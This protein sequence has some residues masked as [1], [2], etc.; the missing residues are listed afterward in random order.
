MIHGQAFFRTRQSPL[1]RILCWGIVFFVA[2]IIRLD[3]YATEP[4]KARKRWAIIPVD[5]SAAALADLLTA[6]LS[7]WDQIDLVERTEI[8]LLLD[9]L[10]LNSAGLVESEH[11]LTLGRLHHADALL[12]IDV[13]KDDQQQP[14][15][16]NQP[17]PHTVSLRLRLVETRTSIRYLDIL[18]PVEKL[19]QEVQAAVEVL[20]N[21]AEKLAFADKDLQYVGVMPINSGEPGEMLKPFCDSLTML[22]ESHLHHVPSI[23]VLERSDLNR[24]RSESRLSG[25]ELDLQVSARLLEIAVRRA[26]GGEGMIATCRIH[27]LGGQVAAT[28]DVTTKSVD[29][30]EMRSAIVN[31][32]VQQLGTEPLAIAQVNPEVEALAFD[33]RRQWLRNAYRSK[34][35]AE[36]AEAALALAP[37]SRRLQEAINEY[38]SYRRGFKN[39]GKAAPAMP[40]LDELRL[41]QR[42]EFMRNR[43][44]KTNWSIVNDF[45]ENRV[46]QTKPGAYKDQSDFDELRR[47]CQQAFAELQDVAK[48][49]PIKL[50]DLLLDKLELLQKLS[51]T[52]EQFVVDLLHLIDKIIETRK[53]A[54]LPQNISQNSYAR[55][56]ILVSSQ[57]YRARSLLLDR[58]RQFDNVADWRKRGLEQLND[59]LRAN[60][61][62]LA[63]HVA[64]LDHESKFGSEKI[65]ST[66]HLLLLLRSWDVPSQ[67]PNQSFEGVPADP[68]ER[69]AFFRH[70]TARPYRFTSFLSQRLINDCIKGQNAGE[71][72]ELFLCQAEFDRDPSLFLRHMQT[73][74]SIFAASS[75]EE[76]L[77]NARRILTVL[78]LAKGNEDELTDS[79]RSH[80]FQILA[81]QR[82]ATRPVFSFADA[83]GAWQSF[84][85]RRIELKN[86]SNENHQL[87]W[88]DVAPRATA[89]L[90]GDAIVMGWSRR[91]GIS[92]ETIGML[93]GT[94]Q[95]YGPNVPGMPQPFQPPMIAYGPNALY[96]ATQ[97]P[98]FTILHKDRL[99]RIT[100]EQGAPSNSV[101]RMAWYRDRL[102][103]AYRDAFATYDPA[104][105]KFQLL[106]S[107]LSIEPRNPIDGR[108]SFF[109][110]T[111]VA[112][113]KNGCLWMTIQDNAFPRDRSGLWRFQPE[114]NTFEKLSGS[115]G[116]QSHTDTHI[117]LHRTIQPIWAMIEKATGRMIALE[118]YS[119]KGESTDR[120]LGRFSIVG[121]HIVTA[122][123][124]LFSPDGQHAKLKSGVQFKHMQ[125]L[126][127]GLLTHYDEH[128]KTIWYIEPR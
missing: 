70:H 7:S 110:T 109:I 47:E 86:V 94:P 31:A 71:L 11:L 3:A 27:S 64:N 85:T 66:Y 125:R 81:A 99:E 51:N 17:L 102:Y 20:R 100:E 76:K 53:A 93:G 60:E 16:Q 65:Q 42:E 72:L 126:G 50:F 80:I 117:F 56:I 40:R 69:R 67:P 2:S 107:S 83:P 33:K 91:G 122:N 44:P 12:L 90:Q 24:L 108:G 37:T 57:L 26:D 28:F 105:G 14:S 89:G 9:E 32:V 73:I 78:D 38:E 124:Q 30:I 106:A 55:F 62:E 127:R 101:L 19:E 21:A 29:V 39:S 43:P 13:P 77:N 118:C 41:R 46:A 74:G 15:G 58:Q 98:G 113:E 45:F 10:K 61:N 23:V 22:I 48:N 128:E 95:K 75:N 116:I 103:V 97:A 4:T 87:L 119:Q 88:I 68:E 114:K 112:D 59:C 82:L 6:S 54:D 1:A 49:N 36:M 79:L 34:E 52:D 123:G 115:N 104:T 5:P 63:V 84:T 8:R 25:M 120:L 96:V 121:R 18:L 92:I 111:M 35:A